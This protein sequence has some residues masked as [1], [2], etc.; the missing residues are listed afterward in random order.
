MTIQPA[1]TELDNAPEICG[2]CGDPLDDHVEVVVTDYDGPRCD[3]CINHRPPDP[4]AP[5]PGSTNQEEVA[6]GATSLAIIISPTRAIRM[7][8]RLHRAA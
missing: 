4:P 5:A 7:E 8:R 6:Q 1:S 2:E 3:I